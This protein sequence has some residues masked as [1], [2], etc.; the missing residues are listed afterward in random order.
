M[1]WVIFV[2]QKKKLINIKK[3][4]NFKE[5]LFEIKYFV[6]FIVNFFTVTHDTF[7]CILAENKY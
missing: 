1:K 3:A 6:K 2:F 7:K 4:F 5:A